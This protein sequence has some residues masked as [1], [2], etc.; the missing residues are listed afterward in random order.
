[1]RKGAKKA[2]KVG[3]SPSNLV[4]FEKRKQLL[5]G[6]KIAR[7]Y[8]LNVLAFLWCPSL[9][10]LSYLGFESKSNGLP[11]LSQEWTEWTE[12]LSDANRRATSIK[13]MILI[14]PFP[15]HSFRSWDCKVLPGHSPSGSLCAQPSIP[16]CRQDTVECLPTLPEHS[17]KGQSRRQ[18]GCPSQV[19]SKGPQNASMG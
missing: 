8:S 2:G 1:M 3:K 12:D 17:G 9:C 14:W 7:L 4:S 5:I 10:G 15:H 13:D 16:S 11:T 19:S 6:R 18:I